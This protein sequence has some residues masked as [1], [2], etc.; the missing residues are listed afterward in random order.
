M[1][2]DTPTREI[3]VASIDDLAAELADSDTGGGSDFSGPW[4]PDDSSNGGAG[5]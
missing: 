4:D 5:A 3:E 1:T 2:D